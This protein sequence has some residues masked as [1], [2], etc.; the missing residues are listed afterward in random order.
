MKIGSFCQFFGTLEY[1]HTPSWQWADFLSMSIHITLRDCHLLEEEFQPL[2][3]PH[4]CVGHQQ[5]AETVA[6]MCHGRFVI[7]EQWSFEEL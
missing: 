4:N 3:G 5:N 2:E 7:I 6:I 1:S